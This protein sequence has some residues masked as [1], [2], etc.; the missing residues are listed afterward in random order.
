[1]KPPTYCNSAKI[2]LQTKIAKREKKM[3]AISLWNIF[4][5][6]TCFTTPP[7]FA[8]RIYESCL[9]FKNF[10]LRFIQTCL[11]FYY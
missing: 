3:Y 8:I 5:F 1:M 6:N 9:I 11:M 10:E 7:T 4:I 2:K